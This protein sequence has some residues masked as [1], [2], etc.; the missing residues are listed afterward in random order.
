MQQLLRGLACAIVFFACSSKEK[1]SPKED[2]PKPGTSAEAT[3]DTPPTDPAEVATKDPPAEVVPTVGYAEIPAPATSEQQKALKAALVIHR[4][5]DYA[6]SRD[7]LQ[8][9]LDQAPNFGGAEY[10]L[11]CALSRLGET[12]EAAKHMAHLLEGDLPHYRNR[13]RD[14][15]DFENLRKSP[16][17]AA[18]DSKIASLEKAWKQAAKGGLPV[19]TYQ[20]QAG[21][22]QARGGVWMEKEKRFLHLGGKV[23]R[24]VGALVDHV[25]E[26]VLIVAMRVTDGDVDHG[27]EEEYRFAATVQPLYGESKPIFQMEYEEGHELQ[28]FP[29]VDGLKARWHLDYGM[30][31]FENAR[32][33]LRK[34]PIEAGKVETGHGSKIGEFPPRHYLHISYGTVEIA[35]GNEVDPASPG[36]T[37]DEFYI[38]GN[39]LR[40]DK[41]DAIPLTRGHG[42]WGGSRIVMNKDGS[43]LW[44]LTSAS[45]EHLVDRVDL[46]T[47]EVTTLHKGRGRA[48]ARFHNGH[49]YLQL[50][51]EMRRFEED[52][53][54]WEA[55][56]P[57]A[58][59][60][61]LVRPCR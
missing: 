6:G 50:G 25:N 57:V 60:V 21:K 36:P 33:A 41:A 35:G 5:K 54:T 23:R 59:Q 61:V 2:S 40:R 27:E 19:I 1:A 28:L 32:W 3:P 8:A 10:N 51:P 18:L 9:L 45:C 47:G 39:A 13:L 20:S 24:A 58:A 56:T 52:A 31:Q 46:A 42:K 43:V 22:L 16:D 26:R 38:K 44:V 49:L 17:A 48:N 34:S 12:K 29:A 37:L 11:A 30:A 4:T 14:D 7:A 55:A 15:P 53:S